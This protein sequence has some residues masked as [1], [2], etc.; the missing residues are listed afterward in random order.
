[1]DSFAERE[2]QSILVFAFYHQY[3]IFQVLWVQFELKTAEEDSIF[4][5][6][7]INGDIFAK[8]KHTVNRIC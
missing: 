2:A 4:S 8:R 6:R 1:M 3:R 5:E 7:S